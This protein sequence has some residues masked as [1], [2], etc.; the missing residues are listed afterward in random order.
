MDRVC[1][2]CYLGWDVT[3]KKT[4]LEHAVDGNN[5]PALRYLLDHGADLTQEEDY[6]D[7]VL[8]HA[9]RRGTTTNASLLVPSTLAALFL[10][11]HISVL[12][13]PQN[14]LCHGISSHA[15]SWYCYTLLFLSYQLNLF[16]SSRN[17]VA[18]TK[19]NKKIFAIKEIL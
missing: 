4:P 11:I 8:H 12:G 17:T 14:Y 18:I 6:G 15:L 10:A 16:C 13:F 5:L 9:A 19:N 3:G 2:C 7:T 1:A